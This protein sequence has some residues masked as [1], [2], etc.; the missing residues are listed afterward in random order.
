MSHVALP[1]LRGLSVI[2]LFHKLLRNSSFF[3]SSTI[4]W[5]NRH[6]IYWRSI[7]RTSNLFVFQMFF[8]WK[9]AS[10]DADSRFL[11]KISK[12]IFTPLNLVNQL[13]KKKSW[14]SRI[15]DIFLFMNVVENTLSTCGKCLVNQAKKPFVNI[16]DLLLRT[17]VILG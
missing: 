12:R 5:K 7:L 14:V 8:D 2:C 13:R 17:F 16:L 15:M 11:L 6:L 10:I 1:L 9:H 4:H 3:T